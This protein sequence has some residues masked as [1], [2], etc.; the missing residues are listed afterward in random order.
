MRDQ[1]ERENKAIRTR[2][3]TLSCKGQEDGLDIH[4]QSQSNLRYL[5]IYDG[6]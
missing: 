4:Q 2:E 5:I 1:K 6:N 3:F